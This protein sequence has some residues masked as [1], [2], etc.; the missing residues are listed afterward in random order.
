MEPFRC[1]GTSYAETQA[2]SKDKLYCQWELNQSK[3]GKR[4]SV[5]IPEKGIDKV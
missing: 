1:E 5:L 4:D 2:E 3:E